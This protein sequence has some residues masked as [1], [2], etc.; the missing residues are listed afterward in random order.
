MYLLTAPNAK[1]ARTARDLMYE[2]E[3]AQEKMVEKKQQK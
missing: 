2:I 1:D 3:Y